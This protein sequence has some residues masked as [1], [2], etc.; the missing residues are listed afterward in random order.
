[1]TDILQW[2]ASSDYILLFSVVLGAVLLGKVTVPLDDR[3][4]LR[5]QQPRLQEDVV[6]NPHLADVME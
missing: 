5:R 4:L 1:M 6:G 2:L 3:S